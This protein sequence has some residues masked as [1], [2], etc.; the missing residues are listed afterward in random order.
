MTKK[1]RVFLVSWNKTLRG[2]ADVGEFVFPLDTKCN[3]EQTGKTNCTQ[4]TTMTETELNRAVSFP[5]WASILEADNTLGA[6]RA[7]KNA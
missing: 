3:L 5:D 7:R 4:E 6:A 1:A 2:V